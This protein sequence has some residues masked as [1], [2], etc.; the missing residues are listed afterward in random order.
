MNWWQPLGVSPEA[1]GPLLYTPSHQHRPPLP[2]TVLSLLSPV[3]GENMTLHLKPLVIA[4]R[5][6]L[7]L[8]YEE[9]ET[10]RAEQGFSMAED[11][12]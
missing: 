1:K 3:K 12:R 2:G 5:Q 8:A 7:I 6:T 4:Q 10:E 9:L 11:W